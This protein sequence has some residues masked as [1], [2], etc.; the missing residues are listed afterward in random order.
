[1]LRPQ[2]PPPVPEITARA[3]HAAFPKGHRYLTIRDNL[4]TIFTDEM[5]AGLFPTTGRPAE[6]P[7][8]LALVTIVQFAEGL[9]DRD[10]ADAVRDR[11]TLRYLLGLEYDDPGFDYSILSRFRD[12]LVEGGVEHLLLDTLIETCK[13]AGLIKARGKSRT[14]ATHILAAA[15]AMDR[16]ENVTETL[17][18]ALNA[19][20]KIE[21]EWLKAFAP[22]EWYKRY[23]RRAENYQLLGKGKGKH[24]SERELALFEQ[25]GKDG[26]KLLS[27]IYS[28]G[29]PT[30]LQ[31][32]PRVDI[33][34]QCWV[35]QFWLDDGVVKLRD[36]D[37]MRPSPKRQDTPYDIEAKRGTKGGRFWLG[38]KVHYTESCDDDVPHLVLHVDT[39]EPAVADS[40]RVAPIHEALEK[41]DLLPREHFVDNHYVNSKLLV[42]SEKHHGVALVGPI[43]PYREPEGFSID[44]FEVDWKREVVTCPAGKTSIHWR[45][46]MPKSGR[47]QVA[48]GFA[49]GDCKACPLNERCAKNTTRVGRTLSLLPREQYEAREKV[50]REQGTWEWREHYNIR[51][52]VEGT[53]SQA[54]GLG[55]RRSRYHSFKKNHL[56][57]LAIAA[58]VNFQRLSDWFEELPRAKTRTSR[59]AA[60]RA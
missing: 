37:G 38:Y 24:R 25:V 22:A 53:F 16:L 59:F 49:P 33:L 44:L 4:G 30:C 36:K 21:P 7:W 56:Q 1:M 20:A 32:L 51:R 39:T 17:R 15:R 58:G 45:P 10:V 31:D 54:V 23:S 19:V 27:A 9:S 29:A 2:H 57:N 35:E 12:R 13:G 55:L 60:L 50:K 43:K 14:D 46:E 26:M 34:R 52:G 3:A 11:I 18:A 41:K 28:N 5:F 47:E 48:V 8:R 40:A 6:A 42:T